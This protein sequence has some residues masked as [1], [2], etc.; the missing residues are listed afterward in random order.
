MSQLANEMH[1]MVQF[2]VIKIY[3]ARVVVISARK[4]T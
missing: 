4:H 1:D 3:V 2:K